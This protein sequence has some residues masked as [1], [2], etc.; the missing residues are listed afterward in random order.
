MADSLVAE[1]VALIEEML[2]CLDPKMVERHDSG[3]LAAFGIAHSDTDCSLCK[4]RAL[5]AKA[6]A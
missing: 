4:A 6:K 1:L 5:I 2:A 3:A